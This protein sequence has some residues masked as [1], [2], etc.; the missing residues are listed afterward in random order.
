M[1]ILIQ[2]SRLP[3]EDSIHYTSVFQ[4]LMILAQT[5]KYIYNHYLEHRHTYTYGMFG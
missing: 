3:V 4:T 2:T 5:K 1:E